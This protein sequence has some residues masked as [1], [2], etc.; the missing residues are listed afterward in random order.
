MN[1]EDIFNYFDKSQWRDTAHTKFKSICPTHD[2]RSP[3]LVVRQH[4]TKSGYLQMQCLA[5][6]ESLDVLAAVGLS[7]KDLYLDSNFS[8]AQK[9]NYSRKKIFKDMQI[10]VS[11]ELFVLTWYMDRRMLAPNE[12]NPPIYLKMNPNFDPM[13]PKLDVRERQAIERLLK[14]LPLFL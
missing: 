4:P 6:C 8:P 3:S 2:D 5:G 7:I 10:I 9:T 14:A 13:L 1:I 12:K 11:R